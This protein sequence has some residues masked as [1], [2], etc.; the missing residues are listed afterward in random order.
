MKEKA[1]F[2]VYPRRLNSGKIIYYYWAYNNKGRR[3]YRTT[4]TDTYEKAVCY[5]RNLMKNGKLTAEKNHEFTQYTENFFVFDS[6]PYIKT[7]LLHG[8]SYTKGWAQAQRNLLLRR[9]IPELGNTDI[10]EIYE[11]RIESWLFR[12]KQENAGVKTLNHLITILRI[13]F[14]FALKNHDVD[15]NPM[16]NI[17]LFA[18]K[19]AEKGILSRDEL[20]RLFSGGP[21]SGIWGSKLHFTLNLAAAMTGMRLGEILA[22]KYGMVQPQ[23]IT[24]ANSWS[25]TDKLK[26][27]KNG[28]VRTIPISDE[29]YR[30]I[31]SLKTETNA[32]SFIFAAKDSPVD[33]KTVYKH[34]YHALANI[35]IDRN[36]CRDR[37]ITFH[38]YRHGFNTMLL[39]AGLAPETVH[40]LTGHSAGM[41]ARYSH[42]QLQ[43]TIRPQLFDI[44]LSDTPCMLPAAL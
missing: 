19:T 32:A 41:T 23:F 31:M 9:I 33:H 27:T 7:R 44:F 35:G 28:K 24:V 10:R 43:N 34:Y 18:L 3:I 29:L 11:G 6:C 37:N 42:V 15:E 36:S 5:C 26:C 38:S 13:I 20:N 12:L 39:E 30:L 40:L 1:A 8:K 21:E 14:G 16:A 25:T 2:G 4:G 17:E 22:L